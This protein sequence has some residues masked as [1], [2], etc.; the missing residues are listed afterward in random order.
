MII[1]NEGEVDGNIEEML[2]INESEL[3]DKL[4]G[5]QG[6]IKYLEGQVEYLKLM[7]THYLKRRKVLEN[8]VQRCKDSMVRAFSIT[9]AKKLKT[10]NYNFTLCESE[11]WALDSEYL[12][13]HIKNDLLNKGMAENIFKI[14]MSG[15]KS[16]YKNVEEKD[17]P[18]WIKV[19][20]KSHIRVS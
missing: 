6:F 18:K 16:E 5:Y 7:E 9:D 17:R 1:E 11:S 2:Q 20:K 3:K 14:S 19:K 12:E 10:L 8:Q 13:D 4:D 15:I